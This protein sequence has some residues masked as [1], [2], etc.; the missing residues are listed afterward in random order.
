M[1]AVPILSGVLANNG[2]GFEM[3]YPRNLEPVIADTKLSKGQL[4]LTAGVRTFATGPGSDR[5]A[6]VWNGLA[7]R[8]MGDKLVR[9]NGATATVL[10]TIPGT[11]PAI[12]DYGFD[13]ISIAA[14]GKLFYYD[15]TA[16]TQVTDED[17]GTVI[18]A[19]WVDGFTMFT[20][21]KFIGV[22]ELNDPYQVKP[23]KYGSA[24]ADPDPIT[25]IIK[26]REEVH[27]IGTNTIQVFQNV[28][29]NGF[30]FQVIKGATIPYGCVSRTAKC[31]FAESFA[32]VGSGRD[33]ALAV[34]VAGQGTAIKISTQ[35][36]D[37][38]LR[39]CQEPTAIEC[40]S[41]VYGDEKR[42][43]VHLPNL[44]LVY[45][46]DAS[47][48]AGQPVWAEQDDA[49]RHG[50]FVNGAYQVAEGATL[51]ILDD[52][53]GE[54]FGERVRWSFDVGLLA[55]DGAAFLL[56]SVEM[57]G[58]PGRSDGVA[59]LSF[60][61]DG[62]TY[63]TPKAQRLGPVGARSKRVQWRPHMRFPTYVGMRFHGEGLFGV[64]TVQ[65][66]GEPLV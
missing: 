24:E 59:F 20:D 27:A 6:I 28:G 63:S 56:H 39:E 51:G 17:L 12:M 2:A 22:T 52:Q 32:F 64:S 7:Y 47:R 65:I 61:R 62:Q 66:E 60:T 58:L 8:V 35:R 48:D 38:L 41:R 53:I 15:G 40:E 43:L 4:R 14:D 10:G 55:N 16:L 18:D 9:W 49:A 34:Y 54:R 26:V 5:G 13:R 3:S 23:Q 29:G 25:G 46:A 45:F 33:E 44:T 11:A 36:I 37:R 1:P 30:P 42:L 57:L 21:G 19:L 50:V 31:R